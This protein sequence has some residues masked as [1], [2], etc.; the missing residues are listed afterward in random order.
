MQNLAEM[1]LTQLNRQEPQ[2]VY[3]KFGLYWCPNPNHR[4]TIAQRPPPPQGGIRGYHLAKSYSP[5]WRPLAQ[6]S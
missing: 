4:H 1:L 6:Q 3:V 2:V 5:Y